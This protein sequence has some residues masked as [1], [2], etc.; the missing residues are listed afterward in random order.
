MARQVQTYTIMSAKAATGIGI[1]V[2][3]RDFRNMVVTLA[4]A[5]LSAAQAVMTVKCQGASGDTAPDFT[6]A[7]SPSNTWDYTQMVDLQNAAA[8][9]GDTGVAFVANDVRQFEVNT[10][11]LDW[12]TLNITA[13]TSGSMTITCELSD[14]L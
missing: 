11:V 2:F 5:T 3:A 13:Y 4:G 6:A 9:D 10:N 14:N 8:I 12:V 1:N 7:Q